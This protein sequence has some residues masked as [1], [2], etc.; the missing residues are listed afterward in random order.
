VCANGGGGGSSQQPAYAKEASKQAYLFNCQKFLRGKYINYA[1]AQKA[2]KG[3]LRFCTFGN[4]FSS[5]TIFNKGAV[6]LKQIFTVV[7]VVVI[8]AV[9]CIGCGDTG[10]EGGG[11]P[12]V[13]TFTDNRDKKVY[14]KVTIG[15]QTWMAENLNYA[16]NKSRCYE[17]STDS[18]TKYG[19]LYDWETAM[20]VCPSGWHLSTDAEWTTLTDFVGYP[21]G[22]K[23]KSTTG[24]LNNG[25]GTDEYG[26]SALPAGVG[27]VY[28][29]DFYEA[30]YFCGWWSS[31]EYDDEPDRADRAWTRLMGDDNEDM[32]RDD[33]NKHAHFMSVR[34]VQN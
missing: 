2:R 16:A 28:S 18:C 34:C 20:V 6:M 31:T 14:R 24:W 3:V 19:R 26:F 5:Y 13:S 1:Y 15:T 32:S 23:L 7:G 8:A 11:N 27:S 33:E 12:S 10:G 9:F 25:N 4:I 29:G 21:D 17:N 30:G 22:K